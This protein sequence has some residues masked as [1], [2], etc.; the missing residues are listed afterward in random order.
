MTSVV[1]PGPGE[2]TR[3]TCYGQAGPGGRDQSGGACPAEQGPGY[4]K[5]SEQSP[6]PDRDTHPFEIKDRFVEMRASG[7]TLVKAADE[8][9]MARSTALNWEKEL[10]KRIEAQRAEVPA[11]KLFE[12]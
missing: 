11:P 6:S 5:L 4:W 12:R 9:D 2:P 3:A 10:K 8:L 1:L 7:M